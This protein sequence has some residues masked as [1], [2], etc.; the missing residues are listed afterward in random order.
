M[1]IKQ[2]EISRVLNKVAFFFVRGDKKCYYLLC[3]K[4]SIDCIVK[5]GSA[6]KF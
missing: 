6:V 4:T 1:N 2:H 5:S 3:G